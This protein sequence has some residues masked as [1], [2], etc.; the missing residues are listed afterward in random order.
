MTSN[1]CIT[2]AL[3]FVKTKITIYFI[4]CMFSIFV[5]RRCNIC[6]CTLLHSTGFVCTPPL[7]KKKE[8]KITTCQNYNSFR[9]PDC[10][11]T[12]TGML[13]LNFSIF[14]RSLSSL[15]FSFCFKSPLIFLWLAYIKFE[16][17]K[18]NLLWFFKSFSHLTLHK[19]NTI[20]FYVPQNLKV[21]FFYRK[22]EKRKKI[23]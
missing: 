15:L 21:L 9:R 11:S 18:L 10:N 19:S 8:R 2:F 23:K 1:I 20:S 6:T 16:L 17:V 14:S 4:F 22:R 13:F 3:T 7:H 12:C 5:R